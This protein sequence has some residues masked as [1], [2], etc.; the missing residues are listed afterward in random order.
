MEAAVQA[1]PTLV[2]DAEPSL[3]S[4]VEETSGLRG[5]QVKTGSD[6]GQS[7]R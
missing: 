1:R 3:Q 5:E 4:G 7:R 2:A 6:H